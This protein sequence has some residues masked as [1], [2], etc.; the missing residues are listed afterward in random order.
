MGKRENSTALWLEK[1]QEAL[2]PG[3]PSTRT[4]CVLRFF[5]PSG[6]RS[7]WESRKGPSGRL[8]PGP[9]LPKRFPIGGQVWTV[10][11]SPR[12]SYDLA[13]QMALG[14]GHI[15]QLEQILILIV[16]MCIFLSSKWVSEHG[17]GTLAGK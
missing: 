4:S 6:F 15:L 3:S 12:A 11:W 2:G 13:T 5:G 10:T 7:G 16:L 1:C 9:L 8:G 14:W 17:G